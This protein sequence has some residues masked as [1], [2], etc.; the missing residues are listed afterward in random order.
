MFN[1]RS[2]SYFKY[3]ISERWIRW[4]GSSNTDFCWQGKEER[5]SKNV[6]NMLTLV[7][8]KIKIG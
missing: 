8:N 2:V 7:L 4:G 1:I 5:L 6:Q 3:D